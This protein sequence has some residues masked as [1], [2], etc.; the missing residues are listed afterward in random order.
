MLKLKSQ[1]F[2]LEAAIENVLQFLS[3][4][5]NYKRILPENQIAD[6]QSTPTQFSFKAAGQ[7]HL[8]LEKQEANNEL[9]HFKGA[10][11]NPFAF[12]LFVRMQK[13]QNSTKGYI[14]IHADVNMI[15]KMLI[16]KPLQKLLTEMANNLAIELS[17]GQ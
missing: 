16:E 10:S 11:S 15:L 3:E 4:T 8:T 13:V 14:E 5:Q 17:E 6:F 2:T 9:L 7:I 12:D 1:E